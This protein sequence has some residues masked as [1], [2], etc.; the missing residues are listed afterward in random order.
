L[1][2]GHGGTLKKTPRDKEKADPCHF[3]LPSDHY[4]GLRIY[5]RVGWRRWARKVITTLATAE[6][7]VM[8]LKMAVGFHSA[9]IA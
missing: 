6:R 5:K 1:G 8:L 4:R 2:G 7:V 3:V 9:T